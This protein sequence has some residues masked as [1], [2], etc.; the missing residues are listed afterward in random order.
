VYTALRTYDVIFVRDKNRADVIC[1]SSAF[2]D[3]G[4]TCTCMFGL[5]LWK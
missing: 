1:R 5:I 3:T 4:C 2:T